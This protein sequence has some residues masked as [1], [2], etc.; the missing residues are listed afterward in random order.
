MLIS[1][2]CQHLVYQRYYICNNV[3]FRTLRISITIDLS[4]LRCVPQPPCS[5]VTS[6]NGKWARCSALPGC[7]AGRSPTKTTTLSPLL[8]PLPPGG[9]W[10][11]ERK[12]LLESF[13][14]LPHVSLPF[15]SRVS[16]VTGP[17][18]REPLLSTLPPP[19]PCCCLFVDRNGFNDAHFYTLRCILTKSYAVCTC[20][21]PLVGV[22]LVCF[23][24]ASE[25]ERLRQWANDCWRSRGNL[26]SRTQWTVFSS[27]VNEQT[28]TRTA[29]DDQTIDVCYW[30]T[31]HSLGFNDETNI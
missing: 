29:T 5:P 3:V 14:H 31:I 8:P 20:K 30:M 10:K 17:H 21:L 22:F 16:L 6:A 27:I 15:P 24:F 25:R 11:G 28:H 13:L 19:P 26:Y 9:P 12:S 18:L 23:G 2:L 1:C 4:H 7:G